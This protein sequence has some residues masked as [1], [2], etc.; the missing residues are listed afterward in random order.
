MPG[1]S[2]GLVPL[3]GAGCG[4]PRLLHG[5]PGARLRGVPRCLC[6]LCACACRGWGPRSSLLPALVSRRV[7]HLSLQ[8]P[9]GVRQSWLGWAC[10]SGRLRCGLGGRGVPTAACAVPE[11][12]RVGARH[13]PCSFV[14]GSPCVCLPPLFAG[15][16]RS[17]L[18]LSW[19][20]QPHVLLRGGRVPWGVGLH[21]SAWALGCRCRLWALRCPVCSSRRR[22]GSPSWVWAHVLCV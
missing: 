8:S 22:L 12:V 7:L 10:L 5:S 3:G 2:N 9:L 15:P 16:H 4:L 1:W 6:P 11:A 19:G 20:L 21:A 18:V 17:R 13:A 14:L